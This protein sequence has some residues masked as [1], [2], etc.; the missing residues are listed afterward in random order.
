M[1]RSLQLTL[2]RLR[3]ELDPAAGDET[4][5]RFVSSRGIL[6]SCPARN[7]RVKSSTRKIEGRAVRALKSGGTIYVCTRALPRFVENFLPQIAVPFRLVTGDSD[8]T[9]SAE[10]IG[11][12]VVNALLQN[13]CLTSWF[14]QNL[15]LDHPKTRHIPIGMDYHTLAAQTQHSWGEFLEPLGQESEL[16]RIR[17]AAP[18]LEERRVSCYV[19]W[20]RQL[21]RGDRQDCLAKID[22]AVLTFESEFVARTRSWAN[23]AK[24]LFTVSP[25]GNGMDCH[26]TW[27]ALLLGTV[28]VVKASPLDALYVGLPVCIVEDWAEITA[29]YL[30]RKRE[31]MLDASFDFAALELSFWA[32]IINGEQAD[33]GRRS[34]IQTFIDE[35]S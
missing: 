23:N 7:R 9:V 1:S 18:T 35:G 29:D 6:K 33:K 3:Y 10:A 15:A 32:R 20:H 27:E 34:T 14:A 17:R 13:P 21:P 31:E 28:P 11:D 8:L 22:P 25:R 12:H 5:C 30:N 2:K 19:N 24:C 16:L 4:A 26:R